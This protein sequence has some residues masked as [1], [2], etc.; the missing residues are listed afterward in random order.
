ML[1]TATRD[2]KDTRAT[3]AFNKMLTIPE[4]P[5]LQTFEPDGVVVARR[6]L[7]VPRATG[8][9][10]AVQEGVDRLGSVGGMSVGQ[11]L[12]EPDAS[13][14]LAKAQARSLT[15]FEGYAEVVE[16]LLEYPPTLTKRIPL[17][18][19]QQPPG[20][21][22]STET[23]RSA[24]FSGNHPAKVTRWHLGSFDGVPRRNL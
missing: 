18:I 5:W 20:F 11:R 8:A 1:P 6:R 13:I 12:T 7:R 9:A 23:T 4:P 22:P 17:L 24:A 19:D 3:T 15:I 16:R 21:I 2:K 10:R 14:K